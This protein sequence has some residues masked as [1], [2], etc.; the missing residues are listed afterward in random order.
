MLALSRMLHVR[1]VQYAVAAE[2]TGAMV[3]GLFLRNTEKFLGATNT[4]A[5]SPRAATAGEGLRCLFV[6]TVYV[7]L[8]AS[9]SEGWLVV[10]HLPLLI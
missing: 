10:A 4:P 3:G 7:P 5:A 2:H 6:R 1:I 8:H 9:P